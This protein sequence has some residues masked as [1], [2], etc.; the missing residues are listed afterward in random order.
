M[1]P[2][3]KDLENNSAVDLQP[4]THTIPGGDAQK[5]CL[6][7]LKL[8]RQ[9]YS[10]QRSYLMQINSKQSHLECQLNK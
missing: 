9:R 8:E 4:E 7:L 2:D 10:W 6:S 1:K 3:S 5:G